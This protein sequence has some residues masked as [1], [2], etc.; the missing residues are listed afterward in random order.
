[1][2]NDNNGMKLPL[3]LT[4]IPLTLESIGDIPDVHWVLRELTGK[5]R[6]T[7]LNKLTGRAEI[8]DGAVIRIDSF[9]GFQTDLLEVSLFDKSGTP[10]PKETIENL[11]ARTQTALFEKAQEISGLNNDTGT[12]KND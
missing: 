3:S 2:S 9:D 7:Y 1:M 10:I 6:D 11:P 4:E 8:K 12:E 5:S